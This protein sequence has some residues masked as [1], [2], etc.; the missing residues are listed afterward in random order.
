MLDLSIS[1][2]QPAGVLI[3]QLVMTASIE[4]RVCS[5][6]TLPLECRLSL[7]RSSY[8]RK[9]VLFKYIVSSGG[10]AAVA[11]AVGVEGMAQCSSVPTQIQLP[12][13]ASH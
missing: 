8:V 9:E 10:M 6:D 11:I 5:S 3:K 2:S 7:N 13:D 4:L 12:P 1:R